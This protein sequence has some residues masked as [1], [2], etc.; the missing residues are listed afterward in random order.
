L[1]VS[2]SISL[3]FTPN[4][5]ADFH[6]ENSGN[7]VVKKQLIYIVKFGGLLLSLISLPPPYGAAPE[8][9]AQRIPELRR[10]KAWAEHRAWISVDY[11]YRGVLSPADEDEKFTQMGRLASELL[12]KNCT[13]VYIPYSN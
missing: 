5:E 4:D 11:N 1:P 10:R 6:T 8:R 7:H 2:T 12:N 3:Q 13:G 9:E